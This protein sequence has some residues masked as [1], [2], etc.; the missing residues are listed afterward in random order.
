MTMDDLN[1]IIYII[2]NS[3]TFTFKSHSLRRKLALTRV[4]TIYS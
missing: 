1:K 4:N 2:T 3:I